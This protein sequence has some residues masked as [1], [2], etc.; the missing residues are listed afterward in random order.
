MSATATTTLMEDVLPEFH[1]RSRH[2]R[3]VD[4][5]P[6]YVAQAVELFQLGRRASLLFKLRGIR[7]SSGSIRDVL[8]G[9]GFT[10]LA[11]RPGTEVVA[12]IN[13]EFWALREVAHLEAPR[14]LESFRAFDRP[15]WAQGAISVRVDPLEDG[16]TLL[17][18]ETR[19][20]CADETAR[21]RFAVYWF[22]IK[23]FSDWLRRDFLRRVA[24]IAEGDE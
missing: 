17:S 5:P 2:S 13:G 24:R 20:R 19:V 15:G 14:D 9:A 11:E 8:T 10:V 18:T 6:E 16:S 12:G 21:R 7:L 22:L 1:F 3:H 4:A 23:V